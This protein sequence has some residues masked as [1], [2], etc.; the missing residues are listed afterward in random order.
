MPDVVIEWDNALRKTTKKSLSNNTRYNTR[1][2]LAIDIAI[3]Y[4]KGESNFVKEQ[5]N[6]FAHRLVQK[7]NITVTAIIW[8]R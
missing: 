1:H 4:H 6:L 3:S 7:S 5:R 8:Y 2:R